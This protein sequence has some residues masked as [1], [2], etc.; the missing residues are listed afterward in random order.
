MEF[1]ALVRDLNKLS[2]EIEQRKKGEREKQEAQ[3][4]S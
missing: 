2:K 3:E 4:D 1:R